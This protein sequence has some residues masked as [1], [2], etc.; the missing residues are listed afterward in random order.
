[1]SVNHAALDHRHWRLLLNSLS[2]PDSTG[3]DTR[4]TREMTTVAR[5]WDRSK[6]QGPRDDSPTPGGVALFA[7]RRKVKE[8]NLLMRS[9]PWIEGAPWREPF[10][11]GMRDFVTKDGRDA[12]CQLVSNFWQD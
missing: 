2:S 5:A 9:S 3:L 12:R 8:W 1:M 10:G 7:G 11:E 4:R 6:G